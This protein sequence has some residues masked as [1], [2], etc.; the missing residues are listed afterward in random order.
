MKYRSLPNKQACLINKP[1]AVSGVL[2]LKGRR[3][4][5]SGLLS[6]TVFLR[7]FALFCLLLLFFYCIQNRIQKMPYNRSQR[8]YQPAG[9]PGMEQK[10]PY[11]INTGNER[12]VNGKNQGNRLT[13]LAGR[14]RSFLFLF[15]LFFLFLQKYFVNILFRSCGDKEINGD[16]N[17]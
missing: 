4:I 9:G 7:F 6:P 11:K 16:G 10:A 8:P 5:T 12:P 17:K 2:Q 13:G 3:I 1:D 14:N 15:S